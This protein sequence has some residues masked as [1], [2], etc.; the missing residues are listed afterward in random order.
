MSGY[1]SE[2]MVYN[3]ENCFI[4]MAR[5]IVFKCMVYI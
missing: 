1:N 3:L 2:Q 4:G 5:E